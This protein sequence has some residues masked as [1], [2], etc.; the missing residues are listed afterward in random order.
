MRAAEKETKTKPRYGT[1]ERL[2][3]GG[4]KDLPQSKKSSQKKRQ[5][6]SPEWYLTNPDVF[7][8]G[9]GDWLSNAN[10][11]IHRLKNDCRQVVVPC[12]RGKDFSGVMGV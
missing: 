12:D 6:S 4:K 5:N 10:Q 11:V 8:R 9:C 1:M 2:G 3:V 7:Q